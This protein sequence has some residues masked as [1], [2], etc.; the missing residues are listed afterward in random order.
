MKSVAFGHLG[1]VVLT[2]GFHEGPNVLHGG[3]E[4]VNN[5]LEHREVRSLL[6]VHLRLHSLG[7]SKNVSVLAQSSAS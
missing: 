2:I 1:L 4:S 3:V 6:D 5:L 7:G